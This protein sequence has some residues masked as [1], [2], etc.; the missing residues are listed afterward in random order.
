MIRANGKTLVNPCPH[1]TDA[2]SLAWNQGE[3]KLHPQ[4]V[5]TAIAIVE[6]NLFNTWQPPFQNPVDH[7]CS[8]PI[9]SLIST[10]IHQ[11]QII[12]NLLRANGC[13]EISSKERKCIDAFGMM[14][15]LNITYI[16]F[17]WFTNVWNQYWGSAIQRP[18]WVSFSRWCGCVVQVWI[19]GKL[20]IVMNIMR[21]LMF[22][23][24]RGFRMHIW[25]L[26]LHCV[27]IKLDWYRN[28]NFQSNAKW[29]KETF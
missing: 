6:S 9:S 10:C 27:M 2:N 29:N 13:I 12:S 5:C 3:P 15:F 8:S 20:L 26:N 16:F 11:C 18:N 17:V 14:A 25:N 28:D 4:H 7:S 24:C 23:R 19:C 1:N 21:C 22:W